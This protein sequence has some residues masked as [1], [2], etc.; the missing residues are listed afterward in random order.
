MFSCS[1][2]VSGCL[3]YA[4]IP[5]LPPALNTSWW[6]KNPTQIINLLHVLLFFERPFNAGWATRSRVALK[7]E[8][9]AEKLL[10]MLMAFLCD[11]KL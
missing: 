5:L 10:E 3:I 6:G 8:V 9:A 2:A 7:E 4:P 11:W 1:T